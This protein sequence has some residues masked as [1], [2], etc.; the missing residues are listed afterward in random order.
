MGI[1][2]RPSGRGEFGVGHRKSGKPAESGISATLSLVSNPPKRAAGEAGGRTPSA[3]VR[4][5]CR[6]NRP[7]HRVWEARGLFLWPSHEAGSHLRLCSKLTS[8]TASMQRQ[9]RRNIA[10]MR[11][12]LGKIGTISGAEVVPQRMSKWAFTPAREVGSLLLQRAESPKIGDEAGRS[13]D[14]GGGDGVGRGRKL[15]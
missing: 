7:L 5:R 10:G 1:G 13:E 9:H 8:E 15:E 6:Q 12:C 11:R 14:C 2:V 3:A 4:A